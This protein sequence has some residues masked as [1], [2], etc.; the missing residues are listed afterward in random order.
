MEIKPDFI[1]TTA[2]LTGAQGIATGKRH[3]A[4]MSTSE[5]LEKAVVEAGKR[6]GDCVFPVPYLPEL[7]KKEFSSKVA[8]MV[9]SVK[10]RSNAQVSC[11]GQFILNHLPNDFLKNGGQ[12]AHLD[13]AAPAGADGRATGFGV[14][15]LVNMVA[16]QSMANGP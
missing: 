12:F 16:N 6:S 11:A 13:M 1:I 10:D 15:L 2:T 14:A 7:L 8:D 4:V 9:N 5:V 3:G